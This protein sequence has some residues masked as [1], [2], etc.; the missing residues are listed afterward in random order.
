MTT[1]A[2]RWR[3]PTPSSARLRFPWNKASTKPSPGSTPNPN[4]SLPPPPPEF[5]RRGDPSP[6]PPTTPPDPFPPL[7]D[8]PTFLRMLE[9]GPAR[10]AGSPDRH[11]FCL[12]TP[13]PPP[14]PFIILHAKLPPRLRARRDS[15]RALSAPIPQHSEILSRPQQKFV[16]TPTPS[17]YTDAPT[18]G[19]FDFCPHPFSA[20]M[21][22]F[23]NHEER[24]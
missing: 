6:P 19:V 14:A 4:S 23:A 2:N 5:S 8:I 18:P 15:V 20:P 7:P 17:R 24:A 9:Y 1:L 22:E 3:Q 13:H 12:N 21:L 10:H 11:F 16:S